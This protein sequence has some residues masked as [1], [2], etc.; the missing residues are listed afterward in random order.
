MGKLF[1]VKRLGETFKGRRLR[2]NY[3]YE[4]CVRGVDK[5]NDGGAKHHKLKTMLKT[6]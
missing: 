2:E 1:H 6:S 5:E 3:F 4:N